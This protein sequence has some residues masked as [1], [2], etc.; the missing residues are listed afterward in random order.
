MLILGL[1]FENGTKLEQ[2]TRL[3]SIIGLSIAALQCLTT[4]GDRRG[5]GLRSKTHERAPVQAPARLRANVPS[6]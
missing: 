5:N 6:N 1:F 3:F 2:V 4:N